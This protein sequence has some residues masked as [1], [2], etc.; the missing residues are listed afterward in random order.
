MNDFNSLDNCI[1]PRCLQKFE[2]FGYPAEY[3]IINICKL[4]KDGTHLIVTADDD[5]NGASGIILSFLENLEIIVSTETSPYVV[6]YLPNMRRAF[7][8][9]LEGYFCWCHWLNGKFEGDYFDFNR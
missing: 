1:C 7:F 2:D 3:F 5:D 6:A 8:F 4:Y 9:E